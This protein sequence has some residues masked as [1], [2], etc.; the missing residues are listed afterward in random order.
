MTTMVKN[1]PHRTAPVGTLTYETANELTK[2]AA[3]IMVTKC[4]SKIMKVKNKER[5]LIKSLHALAD[6]LDTAFNDHYLNEIYYEY[7][8]GLQEG[9][10]LEDALKRMESIR[11]GYVYALRSNT[12][13]RTLDVSQF[14][15]DGRRLIKWKFLI[16]LRTAQQVAA[17]LYERYIQERRISGKRVP[18]LECLPPAPPGITAMQI[19]EQLP[20]RRE[21]K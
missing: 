6:Y 10:T 15:H 12:N 9:D 17:T 11:K 16:R 19:R 1:S 14:V 2:R 21:S 4:D 5:V 18:Q 8:G 3:H 13:A 20:S 7:I